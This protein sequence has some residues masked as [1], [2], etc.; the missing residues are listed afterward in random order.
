M[1][2]LWVKLMA[3]AMSQG[4]ESSDLCL[5]W[6]GGVRCV[7]N[8]LAG[9]ADPGHTGVITA[10]SWFVNVYLTRRAGE[11]CWGDGGLSSLLR[12]LY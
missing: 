12:L 7:R 8:V 11:G 1:W 6:M 2:L 4:Y 9:G 3:Q 5:V 10:L